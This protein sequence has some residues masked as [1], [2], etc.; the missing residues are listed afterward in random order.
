MSY[1]YVPSWKM[2]MSPSDAKE[3]FGELTAVDLNQNLFQ[4]FLDSNGRLWTPELTP[5]G[6]LI[7]YQTTGTAP[8]ST[9]VDI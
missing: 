3:V 9:S 8:A 2:K 1:P 4:C 7:G 6:Q 5:S